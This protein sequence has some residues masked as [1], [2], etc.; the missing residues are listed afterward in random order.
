MRPAA[1]CTVAVMRPARSGN[2][3]TLLFLHFC[4]WYKRTNIEPKNVKIP[5]CDR[6]QSTPQLIVR[7]KDITLLFLTA[8]IKPCGQQR[9][10]DAARFAPAIEADAADVFA[11]TPPLPLR[12]LSTHWGC[13][14]TG[15][16]DCPRYWSRRWMRQGGSQKTLGR[17]GLCES[18]GARRRSSEP[19]NRSGRL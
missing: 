4:L 11:A 18:A 19:S 8:Q 16:A 15:W 2:N 1:F 3:V 10:P 14:Q 5:F 9:C 17:G 6:P 12:S 7:L 13:V